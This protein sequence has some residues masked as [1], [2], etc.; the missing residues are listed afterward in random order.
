MYYK[1]TNFSTSIGWY[2]NIISVNEITVFNCK[3]KLKPK[4]LL[5]YFFTVIFTD[6][7]F[8]TVHTFFTWAASGFGCVSVSLHISSGSF[9]ILLINVP[10][11]RYVSCA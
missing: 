1:D 2:I 4:M 10:R 5:P 7:F 9:I 6:F 3:L 11:W 8:F